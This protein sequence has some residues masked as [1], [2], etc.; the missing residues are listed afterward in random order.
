M[1]YGLFYVVM[2]IEV[3]IDV[4]NR[5]LDPNNLDCEKAVET[6]RELTMAVRKNHHVVFIP[7][8]SIGLI[9]R[10]SNVLSKIE[11]TCLK[12]CFNKKRDLQ[13]LGNNLLVKCIVSF[14]NL[15]NKVG[16]IIYLNPKDALNFEFNEESHLLTE[17]IMDSEFYECVT[18]TYQKNKRIDC[19]VFRTRFFPVQGGGATIKDVYLLECKHGEHFCLCIL[20]SDKKWPNCKVYG[21]TAQ[22]FEKTIGAWMKE[23]G[24]VIKCDYYVMQNTGEIENL[25]PLTVLKHFSSL[26]TS[27]FMRSY[28][29]IFLWLDLKKGIEY[30]MFY[31]DEAYKEWKAVLPV[32]IP[33]TQIDI[34]KQASIDENDYKERLNNANLP[35]VVTPWGGKLLEKVLHPDRKHRG[36]YNLY[37]TNLE[38]LLPEQKAEWLRIGEMIF[39]WCCCFSRKIV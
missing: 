6:L 36:K 26:Q 10:L 24:E 32:E 35:V 8:L 19:G 30:K 2:F 20:D 23:N 34:V 16:N 9:N 33:W 5:A 29:S 12:F 4:V 17:N 18:K 38:E 39:S 31:N 21:Q 1:A 15:T 13:V 7:L 37:E 27:R 28:S 22:E 3:D 25:I 14:N 11:I